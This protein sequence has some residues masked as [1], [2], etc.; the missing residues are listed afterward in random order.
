MPFRTLGAR[1]NG[2]V[3]LCESVCTLSAHAE[4]RKEFPPVSIRVRFV[5]VAI[6]LMLCAGVNALRAQQKPQWMPGQ[7]GLNAGI[8]PS[9]GFTYANITINYNANTYN[10]ANS[11]SI[12]VTGTYDVW[13]VENAFYWVPGQKV[14][15]G[16]LAGMLLFPTPATGSLDADISDPNLPNLSAAGG[17]KGIADLYLQPLAI[18]WHLKRVDLQFMDG[19]FIPTG[20]YTPGASDNVGMGYFGNHLQSGTTLYLTKNKGTSANLFTDWEVHGVRP[21]TENTSKRPGQAFTIEWGLGQILPLKKNMSQLLQLGV[22]G[23]DQWQITDNG[24]SAVIGP[25]IVP[26][27][28]LPHYSVDAIGGQ[29]AYI[30]PAKNLAL[31]FKYETEY[32]AASHTLGRT[33]VFGGNWT[34]R[35]PKPPPP[36]QP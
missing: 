32:D 28:T 34:L 27:S 18:G 1:V 19:V 23:Y 9:P 33:I 20:R 22:I 14:L 11:H 5:N 8:M 10:D 15:G 26:A 13:A 25:L 29:I 36:K 4:I 31:T 21:G 30:M 16:N 24:G 17:G 3:A 7:V 2:L 6:G 12:P 35:I